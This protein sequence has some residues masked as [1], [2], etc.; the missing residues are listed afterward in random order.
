M[1]II[2]YAIIMLLS[3]TFFIGGGVFSLKVVNAALATYSDDFNRDIGKIT[4][5]DGYT[6]PIGGLFSSITN[7]NNNQ[8]INVGEHE[9]IQ[10]MS[11]KG[12]LLSDKFLEVSTKST[13]RFYSWGS[14]TI[15][16]DFYHVI[17]CSVM[18]KDNNSS[19]YINF[20][21]SENGTDFK[22]VNRI[23]EIKD[24]KLYSM[25]NEVAPLIPGQWYHIVYERKVKS[26]RYN[27]YLDDKLVIDK[28]DLGSKFAAVNTFF[29]HFTTSNSNNAG[30]MWFD[31]FINAERNTQYNSANANAN[32]I[33][34]GP[35]ELD[36][37]NYLIKSPIYPD[38]DTF[39][40]ALKVAGNATLRILGNDGATEITS[41]TISDG[42]VA[43]IISAN[44]KAIKQYKIIQ[45]ETMI[46]KP[47]ASGVKIEPEQNVS[48]GD[49]ITGHYIYN[50]LN[51]IPEGSSIYRWLWSDDKG[52]QYS[53]IPEA[54]EETYIIEEQYVGKYIKYEIVPVTS[55]G[56]AGK[57]VLSNAVGPILHGPTVPEI[58]GIPHI[59][60]NI[61]YICSGVTLNGNY[62]YFDINGDVEQGSL[63]EWV[64]SSTVDFTD[65]TVVSNQRE[66]TLKDTDVDKYILFRVTPRASKP[67]F[68][69]AK[70]ESVPVGPVLINPCNVD[71]E[72][73]DLGDLG[74]ITADFDLPIKGAVNF[75]DINWSSSDS[76]GIR[77]GEKSNDPDINTIKALVNRKGY[78][79]KVTLTAEITLKFGDCSEA[80]TLSAK[81][82]FA[83]TVLKT[84]TISGAPGGNS[85]V[86]S[87]PK[88]GTK[89][90]G[91]SVQISQPEATLPYQKQEEYFIDINEVEWAKQYINELA[92]RDI[93]TVGSDKIFNPM[94]NIKREEFVKMIVN[95]FS[96][97]D[98]TAE[99]NMMDVDKY[100][101]YYKYIASAVKNNIINGID[102]NR[103][104]IGQFITRQDM[105]VIAYRALQL[106]YVELTGNKSSLIFEDASDISD[107][108]KEAVDR[109]QREG[110]IM[111]MDKKFFPMEFSTRAQ[112]AKIICMIIETLE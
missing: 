59:T 60:S 65:F 54:I 104:G 70:A 112:A 2:K 88:T 91:I 1:K 72:A 86:G 69:G 42:M 73:I 111:G 34:A 97:L 36:A 95:A 5:T 76:L 47:V 51:N 63:Y 79:Y 98:E 40:A 30:I 87:T 17:E 10:G 83:A 11:G 106:Q 12:K 46:V 19:L 41:G 26:E 108:A 38:V 89:S 7:G 32:I 64:I 20:K 103:F 31:N 109:L 9:Y 23:I 110:I 61:D 8:S 48:V 107:Y 71:A 25:L 58:Q 22:Y 81:R 14:G 99:L 27:L 57:S 100:E 13:I 90:S 16:N 29:V 77:I 102:N 62:S 35:F 37:V 82:D 50:N 68:E 4:S 44:G 84:N 85:P 74:S 75:S 33:D 78:D 6:L 21:E 45:D 56:L 93:I 39:K 66:Y 28:G 55:D 18:I 24:G 94:D 101:W 67:P 96:L 49:V 53:E 52:G 43:A 15:S 92:S 105:A 3:L 80:P